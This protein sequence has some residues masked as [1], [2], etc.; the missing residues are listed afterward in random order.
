MVAQPATRLRLHTKSG[1]CSTQG[2]DVKQFFKQMVASAVLACGLSQAHAINL[3]NPDWNV[4][5]FAM[6]YASQQ[7]LNYAAW[8]HSGDGEFVVDLDVLQPVFQVTG[9]DLSPLPVPLYAQLNR[10]SLGGDAPWI[11]YL[12]SRAYLEFTNVTLSAATLTLRGD[13]VAVDTRTGRRE[14]A[15]NIELMTAGGT[16]GSG[17]DL[18]AE[19]EFGNVGPAWWPQDAP[20]PHPGQLTDAG[21]YTA[22]ASAGAESLVI[23]LP[24]LNLST[25]AVQVVAKAMNLSANAP[26]GNRSLGD[27]VIAFQVTAVPEPGTYAMAGAGLLCVGWAARRRKAQQAL[28]AA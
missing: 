3:P 10:L 11:A 1:C 8:Q 14:S 19:D 17:L 6:A 4:S 13:I 9:I 18:R 20:F 16:A 12:N 27:M 26:V 7:N 22:P 5:G 24:N 15:L 23:W 21:F 28:Q 2:F 25:R